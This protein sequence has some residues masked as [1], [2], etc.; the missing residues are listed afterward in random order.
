M[1]TS[2][3]PGHW[4]LTHSPGPLPGTAGGRGCKFRALT[5][6]WPFWPPAY[7]EASQRSECHQDK[8]CSYH[9]LIAS[10]S[11]EPWGV[12]ARQ[13]IF[14]HPVSEPRDDNRQIQN[15]RPVRNRREEIQDPDTVWHF[16][17]APPRH[18][19]GHSLPLVILAPEEC[20]LTQ[21][22]REVPTRLFRYDRFCPK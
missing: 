4:W 18:H 15:R 6:A 21:E 5:K 9:V 16:P 1:D 17:S 7:P 20:Y 10:S 12:L 13:D 2:G 19:S 22:S 11:Q 14:P 8:R 3:T